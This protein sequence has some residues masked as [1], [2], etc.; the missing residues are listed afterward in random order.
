MNFFLVLL[1]AT[2]LSFSTLSIAK[3]DAC[4]QRDMLVLKTEGETHE[5]CLTATIK[6]EKKPITAT[7]Q[8]FSQVQNKSK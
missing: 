5:K 1:S 7:G 8:T 4:Y 3:A 2:V 6:N